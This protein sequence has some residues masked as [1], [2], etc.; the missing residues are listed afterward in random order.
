MASD[1]PTSLDP[2]LPTLRDDVDTFRANGLQHI[3]DMAVA[4]QTRLSVSA[5]RISITRVPVVTCLTWLPREPPT[6][7]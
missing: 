3:A 7:T 4:V 2:A 6:P 5:S 1:Y